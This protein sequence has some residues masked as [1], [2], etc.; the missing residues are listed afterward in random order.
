MPG[1]VYN[2]QPQPPEA[3]NT[4]WLAAGALTFGVEYREVD[5]ES[6]SATYG[7]DADAMAEIEEHSP[8]GGFVDEGVSIHVCGTDDGHEYLRFDVF[9]GEPHYH[10]VRPSND[11]N[12]VVEFDPVA[13]GDMLAW[14]VDR[15]RTRLGDMLAEAGGAD[16]VARIEPDVVGPVIDEVAAMADRA[17][18]AQRAAASR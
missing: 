8:E 18:K 10:Y 16:L 12:N 7:K 11:H 4:H 9:D 15:L 2:V 3:A 5:P 1:I 17:R 6:L 14:A 13:D